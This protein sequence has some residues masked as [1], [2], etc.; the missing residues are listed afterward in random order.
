MA[1]RTP[2]TPSTPAQIKQLEGEI[3]QTR[4]ALDAARKQLATATKRYE[5]ERAK[6][7]TERADI[8]KKLAAALAAAKKAEKAAAEAGK[9]EE[10][11]KETRA[12]L[13]ALGK[14][15]SDV[16]KRHQSEQVRALAERTEVEKRLKEALAAAEKSEKVVADAKKEREAEDKRM[17]KAL[18]ALQKENEALT[19]QLK[20]RESE[21]KAFGAEVKKAARSIEAI[22]KVEAAPLAVLK[23]LVGVINDLEKR[24][25]EA[26]KAEKELEGEREKSADADRLE[27]KISGLIELNRDLQEQLDASQSDVESVT[28]AVAEAK[29]TLKEAVK[30]EAEKGEKRLA[31]LQK[32]FSELEAE[33]ASLLEQLE[34]EG[35]TPYLSPKHVSR[36]IDGFYSELAGNLKELN[37]Q[38]SELRLKVG[39]GG[40]SDEKAGLVVPTAD[41]I[42]SVREG[43]SEIV[44]HLGRKAL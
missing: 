10:A 22:Q 13:D 15:L 20:R 39:F 5:S 44:V 30:R 24:L 33:S 43:L 4:T 37:V 36:L 3:K 7:V 27:Q 35:R 21:E 42:A 29:S 32:Q 34:S 11:R 16:K 9:G 18:S 38:D 40:I 25:D 26:S 17:Q 6:A 2:G 23:S 31:A 14:E 19:G 8:E 41:N 12:A 28:R 1:K